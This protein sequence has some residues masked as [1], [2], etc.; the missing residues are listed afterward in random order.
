MGGGGHEG[1]MEKKIHGKK[2]YAVTTR[3]NMLR[4]KITQSL[5]A[6]T[7]MMLLNDGTLST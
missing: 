6:K 7:V 1:C 4:E 5:L 2:K 3:A